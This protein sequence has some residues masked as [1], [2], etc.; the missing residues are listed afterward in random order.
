MAA[1]DADADRTRDL[2]RH[3]TLDPEVVQLN[4]GSF[5]ACPRAVLDV[6]HDLRARL[7][8]EP[9]R[10][11]NREAPVLF[12]EARAALGAFIGASPGDL[13]FVPNVTSALNAV[14]RS[15][16]LEPGGE[17]LVTDHEYNASRN[18]LDFVAAERGCHTVVAALPFPVAGPEAVHHAVMS[19]VTPRT[20]LVLLDHVTSQTALA[21]P[22]EGLVRELEARGIPVLVDGA[23]APGM[24]PLD[25]AGIGATWYAGN[26][27]KWL[28][29]PKGVGFLWVR[30]D[31]RE[32]VRPAVISHGAN[33]PVPRDQRFRAEFDWMGTCDPTAALCVPAAID[34]LGGLLPGGWDE[35]RRRNRALAL[36]G[37]RIVAEALGVAPPSPDAMIGSM[38][39]LPVPDSE[40]FGAPDAPSALVLDPLHDALFREHGIE[41]PILTCPG[42]PG[43]LLRLSAHLYNRRSDYE[44]LASALRALL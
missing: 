35:V 40:R 5:G 42:H 37:R 21:L 25:V 30:R 1:A 32:G 13:A 19:R 31:H 10:F 36:E 24:L 23:H 3:W 11:F 33:A 16:P 38:A 34:F 26:C 8:R 14:L 17:L 28:C 12:A 39:S 41:V 44:R 18:V 2:A 7:E 20:R 9:S 29:A 43:R 6:Q 4:H 15:L 27:H 22:I